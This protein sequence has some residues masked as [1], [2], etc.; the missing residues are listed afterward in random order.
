MLVAL[1]PSSSNLGGLRMLAALTG[2]LWLSRATGMMRTD[3]ALAGGLGPP[4]AS[5]G[6]RML[7]ALARGLG[8]SSA[9]GGL[10][11]L[12]RLA[13]IEDAGLC[14]LVAF[15]GVDEDV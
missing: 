4:S 14:M 9:A 1:P 8:L 7:T 6:L 12:D 10:H 11:M 13:G 3:A 5:R 15:A 2:A